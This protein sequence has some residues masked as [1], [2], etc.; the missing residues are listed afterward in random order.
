VVGVCVDLALELEL[1]GGEIA[2]V[3]EV[4]ELERGVGGSDFL[5]LQLN[6]RLVRGQRLP[7]QLDLLLPFALPRQLLSQVGVA[8]QN[9]SLHNLSLHKQQLRAQAPLLFPI[10]AGFLLLLFGLRLSFQG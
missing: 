6:A 2:V 1:E 3:P 5:F 4:V 9:A 8:A 10:L 7:S